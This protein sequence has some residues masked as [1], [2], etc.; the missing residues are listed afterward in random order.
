[1]NAFC[2]KHK[3]N[4]TKVITREHTRDTI[5][6][7]CESCIADNPNNGIRVVMGPPL[8]EEESE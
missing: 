4:M 6:L 8:T 3:E 2:L 1:M 5:I 7:R